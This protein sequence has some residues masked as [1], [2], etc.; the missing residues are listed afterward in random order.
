[1]EADL[2]VAPEPWP[3]KLEV[4]SSIANGFG[5]VE[6]A[7]P[8]LTVALVEVIGFWWNNQFDALQHDNWGMRKYGGR[9]WYGRKD[10]NFGTI[11]TNCGPYCHHTKFWLYNA[12][13]KNRC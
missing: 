10:F 13:S 9:N 2:M 7:T 8:I 11:G 1:M 3:T 4:T 6:V 5:E 12:R